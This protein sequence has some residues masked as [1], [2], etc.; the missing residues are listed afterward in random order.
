MKLTSLHCFVLNVLQ[1]HIVC[2]CRCACSSKDQAR[3]CTRHC[4]SEDVHPRTCADRRAAGAAGCQDIV[5]RSASTCQDT[6]FW[7]LHRGPNLS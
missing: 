6:A 7:K 4:L 2:A 3:C 1:A 5:V